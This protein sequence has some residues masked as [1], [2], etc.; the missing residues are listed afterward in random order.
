MDRRWRVFM[1]DNHARLNLR[2]T[3]ALLDLRP[4]M[5]LAFDA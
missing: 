1:R 2:A 4:L 3:Y 5:A